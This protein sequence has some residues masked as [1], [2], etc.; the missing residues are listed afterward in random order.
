MLDDVPHD[1]E[2]RRGTGPEDDLTGGL[3]Y[4][5]AQAASDSRAVA[6]GLE[7]KRRPY[8]IVN[9]VHNKLTCSEPGRIHTGDESSFA[10]DDAVRPSGGR[11]HART[12]SDR[13]GGTSYIL[14]PSLTASHPWSRLSHLL[15][16]SAKTENAQDPALCY[17]LR[18][19]RW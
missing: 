8:R 19:C 11:G 17:E 14:R 15:D 16:R 6:L 7:E 9:E 1:L 5:H 4:Q 2:R 10:R 18:T 12:D 13:L 3:V